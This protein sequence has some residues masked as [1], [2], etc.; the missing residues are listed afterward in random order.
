MFLLLF[1]SVFTFA[2]DITAKED[3]EKELA[4]ISKDSLL[5]IAQNYIFYSAI[6]IDE[7]Y[8]KNE[9]EVELNLNLAIDILKFYQK[10]N[11]KDASSHFW[12]GLA[13]YYFND[14]QSAI[15]EFNQAI[16][17][18][19]NNFKN[20][21]MRGQCKKNLKDNYGAVADFS[22][23][24]S[25]APTTYTNLHML[26]ADKG[27]CLIDIAKFE[28]N[29]LEIIEESLKCYDKAISL[30][31]KNAFYHFQKGMILGAKGETKAACLS[32]SR[33][34]ELGYSISYD[35]IKKYCNPKN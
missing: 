33:A 19:P 29:N 31:D 23:A 35:M 26:Y 22:K 25:L 4:L 8:D 11:G 18:N 21:E 15:A 24:I 34:G 9:D 16:E 1:I 32:L 7:D 20:F 3:F 10:K 6:L 13:I 30:N 28:N 12:I 5:S 14:F 27:G 2:Q 17:L